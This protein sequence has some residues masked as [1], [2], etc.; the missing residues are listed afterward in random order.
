MEN[1]PA[2]TL[3]SLSTEPGTDGLGIPDG[4]A[5]AFHES[6][7]IR[8]TFLWTDPDWRV[9]APIHVFVRRRK[10][11]NPSD[12]AIVEAALKQFR[13]ATKTIGQLT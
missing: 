10:D 4:V 7:T 11:G 6:D 3:L 8:V 9:A 5:R 1:S 2:V 12:K 13:E